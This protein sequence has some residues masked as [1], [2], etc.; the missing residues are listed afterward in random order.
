MKMV[1]EGNENQIQLIAKLQ[2]GEQ[3]FISFLK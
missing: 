3:A 1:F 2:V